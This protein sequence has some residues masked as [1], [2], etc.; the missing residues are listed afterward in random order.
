MVNSVTLD[1]ATGTFSFANC[2]VQNLAGSAFF[3]NSTVGSLVWSV[4]NSTLNNVSVFGVC[5]GIRGT[6]AHNLTVI[7]CSLSGGGSKG[8]VSDAN[9]TATAVGLNVSN[10][11][12][13]GGARGVD[14]LAGGTTAF[15]GIFS[16]N[17]V[18]NCT[19]EG[20]LAFA[21][22]ASSAKIGFR[23]NRF[24]GNLGPNGDIQLVNSGTAILGALFNLNTAGLYNFTQFGGI[25]SIE[26]FG[27]FA[28]NNTGTVVT[29]GI[30]TNATA[31][32]LGIP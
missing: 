18:T 14:I 17:N 2:T 25:F 22:G 27:T 32:S 15:T 5:D 11:T 8:I 30:I 4:A 23:N 1:N 31:G 26:Q 28:S 24:V 19:F 29:S 21:G 3:S 12:I 10:T 20:I 9:T 16:G 6:S 13:V 7:N